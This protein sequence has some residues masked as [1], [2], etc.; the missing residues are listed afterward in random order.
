ML[1]RWS[2]RV[3]SKRS[4]SSRRSGSRLAPTAEVNGEV[5]GKVPVLSNM[6]WT[7]EEMVTYASRACEQTPT[8]R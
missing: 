8:P 7:F 4:A 1:L 3:R 6:G 2:S 5:V